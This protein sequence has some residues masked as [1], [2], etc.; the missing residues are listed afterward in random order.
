MPNSDIDLQVYQPEISEKTM[1]TKI[2]YAIVR[3]KMCRS[4]KVLKNAKIPIIEINT[5]GPIDNGFYCQK[6]K[7]IFCQGYDERTRQKLSVENPQD[8]EVYIGCSAFNIKKGL[9]SILA[10]Q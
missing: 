9:E 4:M 8:S 6:L 2:S 7:R 5:L 3:N 1:I 10:C